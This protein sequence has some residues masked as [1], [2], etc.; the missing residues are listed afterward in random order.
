MIDLKKRTPIIYARLSQAEAKSEGPKKLRLQVKKIEDFLKKN[1]I[2]KKTLIFK[3]VA[4]GTDPTRTEWKAAIAASLGKKNT[5]IAVYDFSR[6][7]RD[8]RSG[9]AASIPMYNANVPILSTLDGVGMLTGT[10]ENPHPDGDLMWG[11]KTVLVTREV[12]TT[13]E[14]E[15]TTGRTLREAGVATVKGLALYPHAAANPWEILIE[16]Y[17]RF[18]AKD[19]NATD[20]GRLIADLT[21]VKGRKVSPGWQWQRNNVKTWLDIKES[22]SPDAY[23]EWWAFLNRVRDYERSQG[24]DGAGSGVEKGKVSWQVKALRRMS[25]AYLNEPAKYPIPTEDEWV[26]WTSNFEPY[27]SVK[28]S[29]TYSAVS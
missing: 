16:Q 29:K 10:K 4:S 27:L 12:E 6:F 17:P 13:K 2:K 9:M 15:R 11:I 8:M 26:E 21:A 20:Y 18:K 1:G 7:S 19:I 24:Y 25:N 5:F 3:E 23:A 22:V 14:K 28:D